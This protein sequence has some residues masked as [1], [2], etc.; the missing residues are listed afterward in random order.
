MKYQ[1]IRSARRKTIALQVKNAEVIVRAPVFVKTAYIE[2]LIQAKSLWIKEK[3]TQQ[4]KTTADSLGSSKNYFDGETSIRID[5]M[6][7]KVIVCFGKQKVTHNIVEKIIYV[8]LPLKY[9]HEPLCSKVITSK[10]KLLIEKWFNGAITDYLNNKLPMLS[11]ITSLHPKAF[12]VRK[13]KSRW[14]SCNNRGELSFNSLLKML[15]PWVVDYVI[16]HELCHLKYLN[17]STN[18]WQ[19]VAQHYPNYLLAKKWLK[20][21]QTYLAWDSQ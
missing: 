13:Y 8:Y 15:P 20:E 21:N 6:A 10:V 9:Q 19:L 4:I 17:H 16:V 5:G 12:K 3:I 14:G 1:L 7:H 18:F 11:A 2:N